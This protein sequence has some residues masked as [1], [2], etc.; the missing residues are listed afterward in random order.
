MLQKFE[1]E[2]VIGSE[3]VDRA[4]QREK[5]ADGDDAGRQSIAN[6]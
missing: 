2:I 4:T 1:R 3:R 6:L 5:R